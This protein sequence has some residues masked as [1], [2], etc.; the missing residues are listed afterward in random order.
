LA[1]SS[2]NG[3]VR[4]GFGAD[5]YLTMRE[6]RH[7]AA[8]GSHPTAGSARRLTGVCPTD[9]GSE[10]RLARRKLP[11]RGVRVPARRQTLGPVWDH[12]SWSAGADVRECHVVHRAC[13][14]LTCRDA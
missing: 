14:A 4:G 13:R 7:S 10:V 2:S 12:T 5:R 8:R 11:R 1:R 6:G 3:C 9:G